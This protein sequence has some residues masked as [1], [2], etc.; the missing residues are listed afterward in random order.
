MAEASDLETACNLAE[1][2]E[3]ILNETKGNQ[4]MWSSYGNTRTIM[5]EIIFLN[6]GD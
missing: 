4:E 5:E 3:N 2:Y 1:K 6:L